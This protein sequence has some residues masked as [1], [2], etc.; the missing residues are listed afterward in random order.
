MNIS[1]N[2]GKAFKQ[3]QPL[4]AERLTVE[5]PSLPLNKSLDDNATQPRLL[6]V[7]DKKSC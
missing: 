7:V 5:D 1:A 2:V 3:E 4:S 6:I